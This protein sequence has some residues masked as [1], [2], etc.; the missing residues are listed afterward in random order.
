MSLNNN[1][2]RPLLAEHDAESDYDDV[3]G[4]GDNNDEVLSQLTSSIK[5]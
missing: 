2:T 3:Y 4:D 5:N 1:K